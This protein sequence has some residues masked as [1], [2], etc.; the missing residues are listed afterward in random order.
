LE[1]RKADGLNSS[2]SSPSPVHREL[3]PTPSSRELSPTLRPLEIKTP[4]NGKKLTSSLPRIT[5]SRPSHSKVDKMKKH[6]T[7]KIRYMKEQRSH[8]LSPIQAGQL[9]HELSRDLSELASFQ[10]Q[11]QE[12]LNFC[13]SFLSLE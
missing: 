11:M 4:P 7:T 9:A 12:D 10:L 6:L 13:W 5:K 1:Q 8:Q 3:T 2:P